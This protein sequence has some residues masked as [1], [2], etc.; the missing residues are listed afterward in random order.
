MD[1][2]KMRRLFS[3]LDSRGE[4]D[5]VYSYL[6]ILNKYRQ[7]LDQANPLTQF[8]A[9]NGSSGKHKIIYITGRFRLNPISYFIGKGSFFPNSAM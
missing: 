1:Y 3:I 4:G 8:M 6:V 5:S 9:T 2:A 7:N